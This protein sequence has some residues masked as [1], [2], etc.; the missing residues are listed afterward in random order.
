MATMAIGAASWNHPGSSCGGATFDA[1]EEANA[2]EAEVGGWASMAYD[3][4]RAA[5]ATAARDAAEATAPHVRAIRLARPTFVEG[6]TTRKANTVPTVD[7]AA[8]RLL[9]RCT[10]ACSHI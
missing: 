2:S 1:D 7:P 8:E 9:Q 4:A 5:M 3:A 10:T 6:A